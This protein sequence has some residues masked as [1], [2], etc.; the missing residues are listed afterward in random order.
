MLGAKWGVWRELKAADLVQGE[1]EDVLKMICKI[2]TTAVRNLRR[3]ALTGCFLKQ[4]GSLPFC[5]SELTG[6]QCFFFSAVWPARKRGR[7]K[8]GKR[9]YFDVCTQREME[10]PHSDEEAAKWRQL[11]GLF[12]LRDTFCP[13]RAEAS[14]LV[15]KCSAHQSHAF[16]TLPTARL[17]C[18]PEFPRLRK[19]ESALCLKVRWQVIKMINSIN[20]T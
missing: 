20:S 1:R 15:G 8:E 18:S 11:Q 2:T 14:R 19:Q 13:E 17:L 10:L 9:Q 16:G 3:G 4:P 5:G 12:K 7:N 6:L